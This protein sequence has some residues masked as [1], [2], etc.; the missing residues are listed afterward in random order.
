MN[1]GGKLLKRVFILSGLFVSISLFLLQS[2]SFTTAEI[3]NEG[4]D[5]SAIYFIFDGDNVYNYETIKTAL[6]HITEKGIIS[7]KAYAN[8]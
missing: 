2:T 8:G 1:K 7:E 5:G 3:T 4:K 6:I